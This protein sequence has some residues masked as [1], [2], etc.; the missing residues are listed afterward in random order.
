M[1]WQGLPPLFERLA[2][3]G[4]AADTFDLEA[5]AASVSRELSRLLNSRGPVLGGIG[6][7]E[8]GILDW[9]TLQARRD[10]DRRLLAREIRRAVQRFEPRLNL[11]EVVVDADP[12][13]PQRLRVRLLGSLRQDPQ[14]TP[15]LLELTP[16]GGTLEVRHERLD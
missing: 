11:A 3:G 2:E 16:T 10:A 9:T 14:R 6:I 7:L 13:Q 1:S 8:Y 15:L 4:E 12:E 5:L